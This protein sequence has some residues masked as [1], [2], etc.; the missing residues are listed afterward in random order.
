MMMKA[1]QARITLAAAVLGLMGASGAMMPPAA[2]QVVLPPD[3]NAPPDSLVV[4]D[5]GLVGVGTANPGAPLHVTSPDQMSAKVVVENT[6]PPTAA[7]DV[8]LFQLINP[9]DRIVRFSIIA[10][11]SEWT[12]DSEPGFNPGAGV[13]SGRFRINRAGTGAPS[14]FTVDG[15]GNGV[16]AG[17]V[18][19]VQFFNSSSREVK[20][21]F[22]PVD[23]K[24]VLEKLVALPI[25][26]W[27]YR[28]EPAEAV[29]LGPVAEDFQA[30][31]GLSDGQHISTV[32]ASGV[33]L[34]AI[35]G[36]H[37]TVE[38]RNQALEQRNQALEQEVQR[39]QQQLGDKDRQ[40]QNLLERVSALEAVMLGSKPVAA[41]EQ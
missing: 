5:Q 34:A 3:M 32:D 37:R 36:L 7:G 22:A 1:N 35:Q 18:Q 12:F 33:A 15:F 41:V 39:L 11:S 28:S 26:T 25:S 20:A 31:F 9:G 8:R 19:A 13:F 30:L 14:E 17:N 2:A 21:G 16:F 4:S 38:E 40:L 10:G 23:S 24:A 29:H 6:Q 27:H